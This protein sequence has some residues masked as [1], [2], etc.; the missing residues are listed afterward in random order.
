M[1]LMTGVMLLACVPL[2]VAKGHEDYPKEKI[3]EYVVDKVNVKVLPSA[4][5]PKLEKGKQTFA[6]Y[7][8]VT[9]KIDENEVVV[10]A[11]NGGP[12]ISLS[13]LQ[14]DKS[15]IYVCLNGNTQNQATGRIQ[16]VLLLKRKNPDSLLQGTESSKA[17]SVCPV[18]G[19]SDQ[20]VESSGY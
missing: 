19:G 2:A 1:K 3:A 5:R 14:E 13:V 18:I 7:G 8:Y 9:S 6:D 16:R 10:A 20:D 12:R 4:L 15:G 11:P 17:F